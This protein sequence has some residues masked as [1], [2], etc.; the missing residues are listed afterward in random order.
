M[1]GPGFEPRNS[2]FKAQPSSETYCHKPQITTTNYSV[3]LTYFQFPSSKMWPFYKVTMI[4]H[5]TQELKKKDRKMISFVR[6]IKMLPLRK[7]GHYKLYA[8][9]SNNFQFN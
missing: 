6:N 7:I 9:S 4:I 5:I 8:L 3:R 1:N 2:D